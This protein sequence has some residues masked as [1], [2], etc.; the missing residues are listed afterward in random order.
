G[1]DVGERC[2][3][4]AQFVT[5]GRRRTLERATIFPR[6]P[7]T[8]ASKDV[9]LIGDTLQ[10]QG[11][12]G[13]HVVLTA[14]RSMVLSGMIEIPSNSRMPAEHVARSE[15]ARMHRVE[16]A[17]IQVS[18]WDLPAAR[19]HNRAGK[20]ENTS[21]MAVACPCADADSLLDLFEDAG[22]N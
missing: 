19:G 17:T 7:G 1:I 13:N 6:T 15:V 12:V 3:K 18:W 14:P 9:E 2:I 5:A 16:P 22:F 10:R 21:A 8:L 11:F 20:P 4:A